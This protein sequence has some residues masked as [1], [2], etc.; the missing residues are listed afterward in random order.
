MSIKNGKLLY[1]LTTLD[2]FE[3]IVANGLLSRNELDEKNVSF[4]DTANHEILDGRKRLGL[5]SYVPFH[6]HIHTSYDT[7]VKNNNADKE[8]IYLC[9]Y[10]DYARNNGFSV[11][12]I[13]PTSTEQPDIYSYDVGINHIA[14]EIME[15]NKTDILP[16][17]ITEQQRC[18]I[19]MAECL[20]PKPIPIRDFQSIIVRDV[21]CEEIVRKILAKYG[22]TKSPPFI[23]VNPNYF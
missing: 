10:R 5:A 17:D 20:S 13:H 22:I 21:H 2:V 11:L 19:R 14:W 12:P 3:S 15:L 18:L 6:F 4:V 23:D 8:F 9:I 1:H 7:Y 16:A